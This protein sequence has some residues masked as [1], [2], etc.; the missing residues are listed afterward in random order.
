MGIRGVVTPHDRNRLP[1]RYL[2]LYL[3]APQAN[4]LL[5]VEPCEFAPHLQFSQSSCLCLYRQRDLLLNR[6]AL[7]DPSQLPSSLRILSCVGTPE[8][9]GGG[10]QRV[11]FTGTDALDSC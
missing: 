5:I 2:S 3:V 7:W 6:M 1:N 10:P 9:A 8:Y 11:R 4:H